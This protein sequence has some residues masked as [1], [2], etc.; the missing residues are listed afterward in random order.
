MIR[1][2]VNTRREAMLSLRVYGPNGTE[3]QFDAVIDTGFSASLTLPAGAAATLGLIR[4]SSGRAAL[5]DGTVRQFDLFAAEVEWGGS[6]RRVL[7]SVV[8]DE[9]LLGMR[10]LADH[11]LRVAV[12]AGGVVE[13][14]PLP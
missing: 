9:V 3:L 4:Q 7:V 5:A 8:G 11:E 13:I 2:A 12:R 1:G 14:T 10:L 6:W